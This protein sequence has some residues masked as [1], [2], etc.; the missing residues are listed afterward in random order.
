MKKQWT[1]A[2]AVM[3]AF[4]GCATISEAGELPNLAR[5]AKVSASSEFSADYLARWAVDGRIPALESK[6][7]SRQAWCVRAEPRHTMARRQA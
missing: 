3:A 6:M 7:D 5:K 2:I 4:C 1:T